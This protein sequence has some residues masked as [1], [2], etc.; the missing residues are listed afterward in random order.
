MYLRF[1]EN[2]YMQD[3]KPTDYSVYGKDSNLDSPFIGHTNLNNRYLEKERELSE[4]LRD[5]NGKNDYDNNLRKEILN[6]RVAYKGNG[7]LGIRSERQSIYNTQIERQS[8]DFGP[9]TN[10]LV[11]SKINL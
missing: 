10:V 4:H 8:R 2:Y 1:V 6:K 11:K 9:Q 5:Q 7:S 3:N